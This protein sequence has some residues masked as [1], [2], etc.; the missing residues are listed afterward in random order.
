MRMR[1]SNA[2]GTVTRLR[3][4]P[5]YGM[6]CAPCR[7][8]MP[9][10]S[11]AIRKPSDVAPKRASVHM[12]RPSL[13]SGASAS[14]CE[15]CHN[16]LQLNGGGLEANTLG[17]RVIL[18]QQQSWHPG[19]GFVE[20]VCWT[21]SGDIIDNAYNGYYLLSACTEDQGRQEASTCEHH[22][23]AEPCSIIPRDTRGF[24]R[25]QL[26]GSLN[27]CRGFTSIEASLHPWRGC[28]ATDRIYCSC[29]G[30]PRQSQMLTGWCKHSFRQPVTCLP[31]WRG[32]L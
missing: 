22:A 7:R 31:A 25:I 32:N 13:H 19:Q 23:R 17:A 24:Q 5:G 3:Q 8:C 26:A 18:I 11:A 9:K 15:T 29:C 28:P 14:T 10:V 21:R 12:K 30:E 4:A 27:M 6:A 20:I 2:G 1:C 16:I